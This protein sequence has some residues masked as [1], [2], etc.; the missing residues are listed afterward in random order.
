MQIESYVK[1]SRENE[2]DEKWVI[3]GKVYEKAA[4]L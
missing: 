4:N 1:V 3:Q 2:N